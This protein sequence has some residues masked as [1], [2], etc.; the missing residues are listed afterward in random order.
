M[1]YVKN[2]F[3]FSLLALFL[4]YYCSISFFTHS[5]VINGVTIVHSHPFQKNDDGTPKHGH[6]SGQIQLISQLSHFNTTGEIT[7]P[8]IEPVIQPA[9]VIYATEL[10]VPPLSRGNSYTYSLR[11]PPVA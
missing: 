10:P 3:K 7:S 4:A 5:H 6:T 2:G 11:G 9:L 1:S 8:V